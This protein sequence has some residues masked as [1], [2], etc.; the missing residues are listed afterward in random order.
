MEHILEYEVRKLSIGP[1]P[2]RTI[3]G[4]EVSRVVLADE[5]NLLLH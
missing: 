5:R 2:R 4:L 1:P 3:Y